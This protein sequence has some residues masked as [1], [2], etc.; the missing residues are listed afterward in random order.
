MN[1]EWVEWPYSLIFKGIKTAEINMHIRALFMLCF[2][3]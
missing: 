1:L 3:S 2:D